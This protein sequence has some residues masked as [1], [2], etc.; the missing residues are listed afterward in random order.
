[1]TTIARPEDVNHND[2]QINYHAQWHAFALRRYTA[3]FFLYTWLPV[4]V[5]LFYISRTG[6][7][8]PFAALAIMFAWLG[9][10]VASVWW[11]GEFRCP[12]CRRRYGSLGHKK[13]DTNLTR[14]IFDK[15]CS[16]CKLK[17][18]EHG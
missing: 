10:A 13:G 9:A 16:N 7:H 17:K 3:L 12:R 1:M 18:F 2:E 5:A 6:W 15:I 4:S 11:A 14:G 8:R